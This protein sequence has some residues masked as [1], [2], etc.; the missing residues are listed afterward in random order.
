MAVSLKVSIKQNSQ[1]IPN[2]TSSITVTVTASWTYGSFNQLQKSGYCIIDG[3]KYTFTSSFNYNQSTSGSQVIFTKTIPDIK[4][5]S[6]GTKTVYCYAWYNPNVSTKEVDDDASLTLTKIARKSTFSIPKGKELGEPT[7]ITVT[8]YSDSLTHTIEWTCGSESGR[9]GNAKD[10]DLT[11]KWKPPIS[12]AS[13]YPTRT[14]IPIAYK[15]TTYSGST[16]LGSNGPTTVEY[17]VPSTVKPSCTIDVT[18]PTGHYA[19]YGAYVQGL[20]KFKV[21]VTGTPAYG[22]AIKSYK[23]TA[24]GATYT[25]ASF[26]TDVLTSAGTVGISAQVTDARGRTSNAIASKPLTILEYSPPKIDYLSV[27]RCNSNGADNDQGEY[28]RVDYETSISSLNNKNSSACMLK[29]KR[30]DATSYTST[31]ATSGIGTAIFKADVDSSYDV[32]LDVLDNHNVTSRATTVSTAFTILH[33]KEDG[34]ALGIGKMAELSNVLDIGM[35]TRFSGGILNSVLEP[36]Y[37]LNDAR[38][39]NTYIGANIS[40]YKYLNLPEPVTA[41]TFTLE[42]VGAGESGQVKQKFIECR[43]TDARTFERFY[44]SSGWGDW[45][46]TSDFAGTLLWSD[47][48][49]YMTETHTITLAEP[50]SKQRTGVV[51]IFCGYNPEASTVHDYWFSCHFVPKYQVAAHPGAGIIFFMTTSGL[52]SYVGSKYIYFN[53]TTLAGNTNNDAIGTANGITYNNNR[54]VLRHVIGV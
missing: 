53:D 36:G 13:Q 2:N 17:A 35:Q 40:T 1:N 48:P 21:T 39:P 49:K 20:S 51:L 26:T 43:K 54:F 52:F 4:H 44:Y 12:L 11:P 22:A 3:T 38:T 16:S 47:S 18:D 25:K 6:D 50:I 41:G 23:V 9:V 28:V 46:C 45:I 33:F 34:T 19:T 37:D 24:N 31:P 15:I 10:T 30:T 14:S 8:R 7:T 27:H 32:V 42:V 29:Y 5:N